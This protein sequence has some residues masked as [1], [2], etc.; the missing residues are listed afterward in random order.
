M[1]VATAKVYLTVNQTERLNEG[2]TVKAL[3]KPNEEN[4]ELLEVMVPISWVDGFEVDNS[5]FIKKFYVNL[6]KN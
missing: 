3:N 1:E 2:N 5:D 4:D 6:R